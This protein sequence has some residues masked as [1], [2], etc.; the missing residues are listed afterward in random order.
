MSARIRTALFVPASRPDRIP[1]AL[2]TGA[3]KVIVDLEDAVE[4]AA[5]DSARDAMSTFLAE[6]PQARL[7]VRINDAE[8]PWHKQDLDACRD[9]PG[10]AAIL[11]PKAESPAQ[12]RQAAQTGIAVI[13]IIETAAG[14][15][16]V[17]DLATTPGV[18][19]L[20]FGSLD[21]GLDLHLTPDTLGAQVVLDH[22]RVQILLHGRAAGL[23]P[24]LDGVFPAIQNHHG[25]QQAAGR[26]C[27]MGFGGMLCIHPSQVGL[28]HPAFAPNAADLEWARR[29]VQM[30][31][32]TGAGAFMLDGGMVDAPV[33]A[34][35]RHLLA[36][37]TNE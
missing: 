24:P 5:K 37:V 2:A 15:L 29:V 17:A 14:L 30:H 25:L 28:I 20:V 4:H 33:I 10:V 3:D 7:W 34:R 9:H 13:P 19:R 1:K 26:A 11:L 27:A 16:N 21:Y 35:A 8:T 12:V 31:R 36:S 22:A 32:E 18:E 6:Q 23:A